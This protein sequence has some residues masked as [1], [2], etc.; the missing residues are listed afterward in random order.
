[1]EMLSAL[2]STFIYLE[3]EHSPMTIGGVYVIDADEAPDG[4]SYTSW[5]SLVKSRLQLSR[6][7][8]QRLVEVPLDLSFPYW[9][10]DPDFD[11]DNHLPRVQLEQPGGMPE[12]MKLAAEI[13]GGVLDRE[14]PLWDIAFVEGTGLIRKDDKWRSNCS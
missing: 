3:S 1:M 12:L 11:L 4:F 7:F 10:N 14:R 6:V 5:Y 2:D 8:R 13:W 9:I